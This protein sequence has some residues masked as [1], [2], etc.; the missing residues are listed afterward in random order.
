MASVFL[1]RDLQLDRLVA[2]KMLH[3]QFAADESF[4][5]RFRREARAAASLSHHN[6]VAIYD[7]GLQGDN[8]FIVMEYVEGQSLMELLAARGRMNVDAALGVGIG[9]AAALAFAHRNGIVHRDIK[10]GNVLVSAQG[11]IKVAD[12]GIATVTGG[13]HSSLTQAGMVLGTAAYISPEQARGA[14]VDAR[15]DLYSLGVVLYESLAGHPPFKGDSAASLTY[16]H[17]QKRPTPI[18]ERG[19]QVPAE[20]ESVTMRLL[21]KNP[22]ERYNRAE[23]LLEHLRHI[24]EKVKRTQRVD[25]TPSDRSRA[26]PRTESSRRRSGATSQRRKR[27]GTEH[28]RASRQ[29][30]GYSQK[31]EKTRKRKG[32][33][34]A[35]LERQ[36]RSGMFYAGFAVLIVTLV[37]LVVVLINVLRDEETADTPST[38]LAEVPSVYRLEEGEAVRTLK[39]AGFEVN[40]TYQ[41]NT[42]IDEGAVSSQEPDG[43]TRAETGSTVEL[44]VSSG[45]GTVLV[46]N[47][48]GGQATVALNILRELGLEG[49]ATEVTHDQ[50]KGEV[51]SQLPAPETRI[52]VGESVFL[53]ISSGPADIQVPEV[54]G[55]QRD[56]ARA[57][58]ETAG[59]VVVTNQEN[60]EEVPR[61]HATRTQ[62]SAGTPSGRGSQVILYI[63]TGPSVM[64]NLVGQ[65][66]RAA[67]ALLDEWCEGCYRAQNRATL[68]ETMI[69]RVLEQR[70]APGEELAA[71]TEVVLFVGVAEPDAANGGT[72]GTNGGANGTNGGTSGTN[73]GT[74]EVDAG[75][76]NGEDASTADLPPP[77]PLDQ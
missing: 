42:S 29:P 2:V 46:P 6:I 62:P 39:N 67:T 75:A 10:P 7:W 20:L 43:G 49:V 17:A 56:D 73:G 32:D 53:D 68:D 12:F 24:R 71:E 48:V 15:S 55:R 47:L 13:G 23:E 54:K 38:N 26:A 59:F 57:D 11:R 9:V 45:A 40:L 37:V 58:L 61:D 64:P 76:S 60:S 34:T 19:I 25:R 65:D 70:P 16:Q 14:Q 31:G 1:A 74:S 41:E 51:V 5:E 63:S 36:R 72:N 27:V 18:G 69:G 44:T 21:A 50:P 30:P 3:P 66:L 28:L 4:A 8:Y 35:Y 77:P 52:E 22:A 33:A